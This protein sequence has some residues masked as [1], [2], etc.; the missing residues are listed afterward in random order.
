MSKEVEYI[1]E[2]REF[3][4]GLK[5]DFRHWPVSDADPNGSVGRFPG[6]TV[7]P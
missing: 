1:G 5:V 3:M 7:K 6:P 4:P 2:K